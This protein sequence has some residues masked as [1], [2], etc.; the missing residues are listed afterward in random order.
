MNKQLF[1]KN[2]W[3]KFNFGDIVQEVRIAEHNPIENGI[4]R[5]I[6][7]EHIDSEDLH[8]KSW[9]NI[10]DGTTFSRKFIKGQLLFGRRRAYLKKA[11]IADFDG[12]CSG[13]ILVFEAIKG[14]LIPELLPFIVQNDRFFNFAVDASAG[15]LSPRVKFKDLAKFKLTLPTS[16]DE[17]K[18][19]ADLLWAGDKLVKKYN[20]LLNRSQNHIDV[21]ISNK[22][23]NL[24]ENFQKVSELLLEN[25]MYGASNKAA[26]YI[27][28]QSRYVR[29]TD[30]DDNGKLKNDTKVS[31]D[32]YDSKYELKQND[33][34][35]VRTAEPGKSF[36]YKSSMGKCV[37]AGYLIK[38]VF[39]SKKIFPD[40]FYIF[41]KTNLYRRQIL[42]RQ[43]K[44][45]LS[46]INSSQFQSIRLNVPNK[47]EQEEVINLYSQLTN[48]I[49]DIN[50]MI[51][52]TRSLIK[53]ITN[54]IF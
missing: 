45:T 39:D 37:Y 23:M 48:N 25:P 3:K 54:G 46:N 6:G 19:L 13:D 51:G 47:A 1:N 52:I 50:K 26:P 17:Q 4:K 20:N 2:H 11:A 8:I 24:P 36:I 22:M 18:E 43:K 31:M 40:Y 41:T 35:L 34:L 42:R 53:N 15:S 28:N 5:Y 49:N 21:A 32:N 33:I 27:N 16:L 38:F 44:G 12:I 29:I 7:L 10:K 30:I 14:K 9:G